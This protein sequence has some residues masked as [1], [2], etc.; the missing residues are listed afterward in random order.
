MPL[1]AAM[2][3]D[4]RDHGGRPASNLALQRQTNRRRALCRVQGLLSLPVVRP[5]SCI[6]I[7]NAEGD[8]PPAA[9]DGGS[10][11]TDAQLFNGLSH[12]PRYATHPLGASDVRQDD[13]P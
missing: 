13:R 2:R 1:E 6:G 11:L 9:L 12:P 10:P 7:A 8:W 5:P 3:A 4:R